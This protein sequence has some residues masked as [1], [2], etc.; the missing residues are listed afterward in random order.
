MEKKFDFYGL[1][2]KLNVPALG[3][4]QQARRQKSHN[5]AVNGLHIA[6]NTTCRFAYRNRPG[7]TKDLQQLPSFSR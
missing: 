3:A 6:F 5:V 4:V 1:V 7:A 2:G